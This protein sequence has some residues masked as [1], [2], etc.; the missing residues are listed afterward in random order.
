MIN[1][2]NG[3]QLAYNG[4]PLY[5]YMN[6]PPGNTSGEGIAG[7]WHVATPSLT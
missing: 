7:V 5:R 2:G 1:S 4:H 3:A 6:T